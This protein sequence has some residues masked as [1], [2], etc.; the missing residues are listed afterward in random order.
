MYY[1]KKDPVYERQTHCSNS[2]TFASFNVGAGKLQMFLFILGRGREE[3]LLMG[4]STEVS[5]LNHNC[6]N[7]LLFP[8]TRKRGQ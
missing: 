7:G 5:R 6:S 3:R 2:A 8:K 1:E 4:F